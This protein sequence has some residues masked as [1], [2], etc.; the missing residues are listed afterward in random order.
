MFPGWEMMVSTCRNGNYLHESAKGASGQSHYLLGIIVLCFFP[1][2]LCSCKLLKL[3]Y[4]LN[5]DVGTWEANKNGFRL[6]SGPDFHFNSK[7][8]HFL[9]SSIKAE[10][11][12]AIQCGA[13]APRLQ[14]GL[15]LI[16]QFCFSALPSP[17][18]DRPCSAWPSGN[19]LPPAC[20][21]EGV[22]SVG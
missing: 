19:S 3:K 11:S 1:P 13:L 4:Y 12:C 6:S 16:C 8:V 14:N 22:C 10:T 20:P 9:L 18:H 5:C 2:P 21:L 7:L 15:A 17:W